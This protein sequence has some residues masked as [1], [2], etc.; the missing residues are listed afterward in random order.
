MI[1]TMMIIIII[2][3]LILLN[4]L[5]TPAGRSPRSRLSLWKVKFAG[6]LM[7]PVMCDVV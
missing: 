1:I 4:N 7:N 3:C 6:K 5:M 2:I